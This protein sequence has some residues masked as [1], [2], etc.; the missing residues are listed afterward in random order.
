MRWVLTLLVAATV[1]TAAVDYGP[2][3]GLLATHVRDGRVDYPALGRDS[4]LAGWL[5]TLAEV[6]FEGEKTEPERLALAINAYNTFVLAGLARQPAA[7]SPVNLPGFFDEQS[8]PLAGGEVVLDRLLNERI[9][10][11]SDPRVHAAICQ[12]ASG[13]PVLRSE[14][15]RGE[16][17]A[18][19]LDDQV[20]RFVNQSSLNRVD[21]EA[22]KLLLSRVFEWYRIDF[23]HA[24][25]AA[26]FVRPYLAST[27]DQ[28]WLAAGDFTIEY[29]KF[30]W[31]LNSR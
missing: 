28:D 31:R 24:G 9:R 7:T 8:W 1:A 23:E 17:L 5:Q 11:A 29:L 19:Q 25:G 30:D 22:K 16:T 21:Q 4:R 12:G 27:A 26:A 20:R 10:S 6:R 13:S 3:A 2:Y 15:Y 14:P 18:A